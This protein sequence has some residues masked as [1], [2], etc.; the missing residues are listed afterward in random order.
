MSDIAWATA[1]HSVNTNVSQTLFAKRTG[2]L[3]DPIA[4]DVCT[5]SSYIVVRSRLLA[6]CSRRTVRSVTSVTERSRRAVRSV[7]SVTERLRT[8]MITEHTA[9]LCTVVL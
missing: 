5:L 4:T 3:N 9:V 8:Q 1:L 6:K 7:T 2:L